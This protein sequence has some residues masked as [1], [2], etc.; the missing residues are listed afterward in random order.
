MGYISRRQSNRI[1][2]KLSSI[3]VDFNADF[4]QGL[5]DSNYNLEPFGDS[6]LITKT[7]QKTPSESEI[8]SAFNTYTDVRRPLAKY[9]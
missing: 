3:L 8:L 9:R 4:G 6:I 7:N 2:A 5:I 1:A